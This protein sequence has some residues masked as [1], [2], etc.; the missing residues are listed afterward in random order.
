MASNDLFTLASF[1]AWPIDLQA[2]FA[3]SPACRDSRLGDF[4]GWYSVLLAWRW[5]WRDSLQMSPPDDGNYCNAA[6]SS[7]KRRLPEELGPSPTALSRSLQ[8]RSVVLF[9]IRTTDG[10]FCGRPSWPSWP[11]WCWVARVVVGRMEMGASGQ[12][13]HCRVCVWLL[14]LRWPVW[15]ARQVI[16]LG[17]RVDHGW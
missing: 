10:R 13:L 1:I 4:Y 8:V 5:W 16:F 3:L 14:P 17:V 11:C 12:R 2:S 15:C 9:S 6:R 7:R